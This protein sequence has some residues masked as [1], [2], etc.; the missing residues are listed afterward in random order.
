MTIGEEG[1]GK[2]PHEINIWR[3]QNPVCWSRSLH[4]G[5]APLTLVSDTEM[6][7]VIE[8][9]LIVLSSNP[10]YTQSFVW[11]GGA[12]WASSS[13]GQAKHPFMG[14]ITSDLISCYHMKLRENMP[15]S[16]DRVVIQPKRIYHWVQKNCANAGTRVSKVNSAGKASLAAVWVRLQHFLHWQLSGENLQVVLYCM[17]LR[18]CHG[19]IYFTTIS[20][21]FVVPSN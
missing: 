18:R 7:W 17:I 10:L 6:I 2:P 19:S 15:G 9:A 5:H 13:Q 16:D 11:N 4:L 21:T 20:Y 3:N 8:V 14:M 1:E 12:L